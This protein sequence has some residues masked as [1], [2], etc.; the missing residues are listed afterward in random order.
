MIITLCRRVAVA[1]LIVVLAGCAGAEA[2]RAQAMEKGAEFFAAE[3]YVKARVEFRNALQI[4]PNDPEA[5]YQSGRVAEQLGEIREAAQFY[6]GAIDVRTDHPGARADLARLMVMT[7]AP[8]RALDTLKP[9]LDAHPDDAGMLTVRAV[10]RSQLGDL[11]GSFADA[12]RANKLS[13]Q[14]PNA[15]AVLA[16]LYTTMGQRERARELLVKGVQALPREVDLR[17]ALAQM[18]AAGGDNARA[19]A[20]LREVVKLK[21]ADRAHRVRLAQ[22]LASHGNDAGAEAE[23][24]AGLATE[25]L[26]GDRQ[27]AQ[28]LVDFLAARRG[29]PAAE[30][31]LRAMMARDP[32]DAEVGFALGRFHE[33][34]GDAKAAEALYRQMITDN[35]SD[36]AAS[37][38]RNRLAALLVQRGDID[39]AR[40]LVDEVLAKSPR[41]ND[42]LILR[43]NLARAKGD[44]KAAIADLRSVL[45]DQPNAI[46]VL[47]AL[48]QAHVANGEPALA[49]E[50][51]RRA[52]DA[53]PADVGA[54][55][56]TAMLLL[57]TGRLTQAKPLLEQL[58]KDQPA[59]L[60]V[61]D[62]LFRMNVGLRDAAG[63]K[64]AAAALLAAQPQDAR[65][66][67]YT[68]M[69]AES[70][71][72]PADAVA[73]YRRALELRPDAYE[74]LQALARLLAR[75]QRLPEA[76]KVLD[77]TIAAQP[78]SA[79][80]ANLKGE[81]LLGD[82]RYAEADA[83]F[84]LA[85]ERT[86]K[87]WLPYR[88]RAYVAAARGDSAAGIAVLQQA[89]PV[90]TE[91]VPAR[92]ELATLYEAVGKPEEAIREYEAIIKA[93]PQSVLAA[94]NL[95]MLLVTH[96]SDP[97]SLARAAELTRSFAS[98][99]S[100]Q[101]L[102]TYGWVAFRSGNLE[103]ALPA[104]E[105]AQAA[106]PDSPVMRY[107]LGMAQA[108]A[109]Q[110]DKARDNLE[111][112][113]KAGQ[114]FPGIDEART[115]LDRLRRG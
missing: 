67:L 64:V 105:K 11:N 66:H 43:G 2:R 96:R 30:A 39:A 33:Q 83:A 9:G 20:L 49:E 34:G 29:R 101:L 91:A 57:D 14:D 35:R 19:E 44:S 86:P 94:N 15:I 69:V 102:N 75:E 104:L 45:R 97:A 21:P 110:V 62:A 53:N 12:E 100:P 40:K 74:P 18:S 99:A 93:A 68:G 41:D 17:L 82:K 25:A 88:G 114:K 78:R 42:A 13:P 28:A 77:A 48:A 85:I 107:H 58:A 90:V 98:T 22:F 24:R 47:R 5:R 6:Q 109:G 103:V 108:A 95:S 10:A 27:L 38:A 54:R 59:D 84:R 70:E 72:R 16:G 76:V 50:A 52:M 8:Q 26:K 79:F 73:N 65:G 56:D 81:L 23:L 61:L 37:G 51:L 55:L 111:A 92:A 115:T 4:A 7:G 113:L 112:A 31:E 32:D 1:A 3:N 60:T 87:W 89:L 46:G 106:A 63:A 80:A 71:R 36:A